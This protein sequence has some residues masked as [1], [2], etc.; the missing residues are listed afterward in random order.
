MVTFRVGLLSALV[1]SAPRTIGA[2]AQE[3]RFADDFSTRRGGWPIGTSPRGD[4]W[5]YAND[6]YRILIR[7]LQ[8]QVAAGQTAGIPFSGRR[9]L[10]V[11]IGASATQRSGPPAVLHGLACGTSETEL[12]VFLINHDG[13]YAI[14]RDDAVAGSS[15][16]LAAGTLRPPVQAG[17]TR[18][19]IEVQ[20]VGGADAARLALRL[21]GGVVVET[22]GNKG[23]LFDR[24]AF[25]VTTL[26][27]VAGSTASPAIARVAKTPAS[28][29]TFTAEVVFDDFSF[30]GVPLEP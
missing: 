6:A 4:A 16:L 14:V 21:N 19:Q 30:R 15:D 13:D 25:D 27:A 5:G 3:V 22:R 9:F 18:N 12:Y 23:A 2:Q 26:Q 10:S 28:A 7:V 17:A 1:F 8:G 11:T 29:L 24:V 20:C